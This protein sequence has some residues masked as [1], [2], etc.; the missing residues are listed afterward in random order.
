M[1]YSFFQ[2]VI[3]ELLTRYSFTLEPGQDLV[4]KW[5][6]VSRPKGNVLVTFNPKDGQK[7]ESGCQADREGGSKCSYWRR[8]EYMKS[9]TKRWE[10]V[11]CLCRRNNSRSEWK[12]VI[13]IYYTMRYL[14]QFCFHLSINMCLFQ[15]RLQKCHL[16]IALTSVFD[17]GREVIL[18]CYFSY[19]LPFSFISIIMD[20]SPNRCQA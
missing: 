18:K 13:N 5:L 10:A 20:C 4:H 12:T 16:S 17:V 6:P 7:N 19:F 3:F 2:T 9:T 15:S 1:S 8:E 14:R 11:G